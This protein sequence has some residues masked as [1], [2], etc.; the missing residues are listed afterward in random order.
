MKFYMGSYELSGKL[1]KGIRPFFVLLVLF[2]LAN[3]GLAQKKELKQ[4]D[5][6]FA[7]KNYREASIAYAKIFEKTKDSTLLL[8]QGDCYFSMQ[9]YLMAQNYYGSFFTDSVFVNS[10]Q[11]FNYAYCA[12][13]TGNVPLLVTLNKKIYQNT[14][15][16]S[17]KS[18]YD[19]YA[20]YTD[21]LAFV[22]SYDL[23]SSYTCIALD[24]SAAIDT[25]AVPLFYLWDFGEGQTKEGVSVD[26]CFPKPG[27]YEVVLS[28]MDR[29]TGYTK[30]NDT[31]LSI[32][33]DDQPVKFLA[34]K[35]GRRYFYLD[36]DA[37]N[38]SL[39]AY[40]IVDHVWDLGTGETSTGKK[41]K[42]KYNEAGDYRLRLTLIAENVYSK[43]RE[44]FSAYKTI[45][46]R[47]NYEMPS[48]KFSDD[49]EK[50]K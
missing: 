19:V 1:K 44:L 43:K 41:I 40:T 45:S 15:D 10:P 26:H 22:R 37:S 16:V 25:M 30:K 34:P 29:Q 23:D 3:N 9:N 36:F 7:Q 50:A 6:L 24:A 27:T 38:I 21:S 33:I 32:V 42:Y 35:I 12:K 17:A 8:K 14:Q 49:L 39:P 31:T 2:L 11:Y 20:L 5:L 28:I 46:I 13:M 48:K 47:E 18:L 4:A